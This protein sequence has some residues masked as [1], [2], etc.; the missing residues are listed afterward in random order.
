MKWIR[1]NKHWYNG[2]FACLSHGFTSCIFWIST[3][4]WDFGSNMIQHDPTWSNMIQPSL[5]HHWT[6]IEPSLNHG[7]WVGLAP[8]CHMRFSDAPPPATVDCQT[9]RFATAAWGL[10]WH[11]W[12]ATPRKMAIWFSLISLISLILTQQMGINRW[13]SKN[14]DIPL[15]P[16][17]WFLGQC[18]LLPTLKN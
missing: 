16:T 10:R 14:K 11:P 2:C 6:I 5:N 12:K 7:S 8:G 1:W 9:R 15:L 3:G 17:S 13:D 4:S 18:V